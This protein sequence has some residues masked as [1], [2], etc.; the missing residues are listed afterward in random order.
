[1]MIAQV[2]PSY[3]P[4]IGGVQTHVREISTRLVRK[5]FGVEVL[6]TDPTRTLSSKEVADGVVIR[7]FGSWAPNGAYYFSSALRRYLK[8]N[9]SKYDLIHAH[10]YHAFPALYAAEAKRS[11]NRLVFTPRYHGAGHTSLRNFLHYPYKY[12]AG[13]IFDRSDMIICLSKSEKKL[14]LSKFAVEEHK[15]TIIPNGINQNEF[16]PHQKGSD[17]VEKRILCVSRLEKYKGIEYLI[18]VVPMLEQVRLDIVG[19]GPEEEKLR[20]LVHRLNLQG[21]VTIESN[22]PRDRLI[23]KYAEADAFALLS[24]YEAFGNVVAEALASGTRCVLAESTALSDWIDNENCYG[25]RYPINLR[26]LA[27]L[28]RSVIR[29]SAEGPAIA[30]LLDWNDVVERL[31][32]LYVSLQNKAE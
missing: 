6:T 2:S 13:R 10:N 7:R 24:K 29:K 15:L 17:R 11:S 19:V 1:M 28:I 22:I 31:T 4:I 20:R 3:Y 8:K 21:R 12:L 5:G 32:A 23:R 27:D 18:R 16:L 30:R 14:L 25:I 26:E 9:A